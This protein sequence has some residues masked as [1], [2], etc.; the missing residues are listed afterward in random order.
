MRDRRGDRIFT[1]TSSRRISGNSGAMSGMA[2]LVT[3]SRTDARHATSDRMKMLSPVTEG[4]I[5]LRCGVIAL[6]TLLPDRAAGVPFNHVPPS[7]PR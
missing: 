3:S 7:T 4:I 6:E 2:G 1:G 5:S